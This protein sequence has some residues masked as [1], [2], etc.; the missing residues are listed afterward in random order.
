M[1]ISI[2]PH[3]IGRSSQGVVTLTRRILLT[4]GLSLVAGCAGVVKQSPELLNV[5]RVGPTNA[6]SISRP[7]M[8]VTFDR[9]GSNGELCPVDVAFRIVV[10]DPSNGKVIKEF[11]LS[12]GVPV[13]A[14]PGN[15]IRWVAVDTAGTP[16]PQTPGFIFAV[17]FHPF[18]GM[19]NNRLVSSFVKNG[20]SRYEAGPVTFRPAAQLPEGV[21]YKYTV[22]RVKRD[23]NGTIL[24]DDACKPLDPRIR[25]V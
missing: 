2:H 15:D 21:D 14:T 19:Q 13:E 3:K 1:G 17:T 25:L 5:L 16:V 6:S 11:T 23:A 10:K 22:V 9:V 20:P 24:I 12:T 8:L 18:Q 4:L 7:V